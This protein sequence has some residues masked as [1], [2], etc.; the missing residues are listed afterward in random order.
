L[1]PQHLATEASAIK[2][3]LQKARAAVQ[4]LPDM[5]RTIEE[6]EVEIRELEERVRAQREV[7]AGLRKRHE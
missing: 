7:L 6:Q 1:E 2:I 5:G 4:A 3:R